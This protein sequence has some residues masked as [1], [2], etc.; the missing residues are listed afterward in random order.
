M[1]PEMDS[2]A[3]G[4]TRLQGVKKQMGEMMAKGN[5]MFVKWPCNLMARLESDL[6]EAALS[7]SI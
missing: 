2:V 3:M 5:S 4:R 7:N 6:Q 1:N